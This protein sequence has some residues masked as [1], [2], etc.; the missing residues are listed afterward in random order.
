MNYFFSIIDKNYILRGLTLFKSFK[1]FLNTK[2]KFILVTVDTFSFEF[3]KK[4]NFKNLLI[5][6]INEFSNKK[7]KKIRQDRK[8]NEF[9]WTLKPI[10][11]EYIFYK[12]KNSKWVT[13]LDSD[14]MIYNDLGKCLDDK[15]DVLLTPHRASEK[16]CSKIV[17]NVGFYNAGFIAFKRSKNSFNALKFWKFKCI[18]WCKDFP[19]NNRY[20]DQ[21]Y[22][23]VIP[24]KFKKVCT[25]PNIG[26]NVAPWNIA[27]EKNELDINL[28]A[29][30]LFFYHMQGLKI[31]NK[32]IYQIYSDNYEVND[33]TFEVIYKPYIKLLKDTYDFLNTKSHLFYQKKE[34][35]F[36]L[37][38]IIKKIIYGRK[39]LKIV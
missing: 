30:E 36:D 23:D 15:Y 10:S 19:L 24:Y 34:F 38:F 1:P 8:I 16:Y 35:D 20:A 37:N 33:K 18:N 9:C 2:N 28:E 39:N 4:I 25:K 22:L 14:S 12:F 31:Y 6:N 7:L 21:K 26:L 11:I 32:Y 29:S 17:Q 27:N 13:Y 5:I 3:I